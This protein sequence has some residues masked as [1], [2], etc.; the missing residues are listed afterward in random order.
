MGPFVAH[1]I[2]M[3][4]KT[5]ATSSKLHEISSGGALRLHKARGLCSARRGWVPMGSRGCGRCDWP[6]SVLCQGPGQ[7]LLFLAA[8]LDPINWSRDGNPSMALATASDRRRHVGTK[9]SQHGHYRQRCAALKVSLG[10]GVDV[11]FDGVLD[12]F[13]CMWRRRGGQRKR[14]RAVE[15]KAWPH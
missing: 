2:M 3:S 15:A 5:S 10:A 1:G 6:R 4:Q 12:S 14:S 11:D 7:T 13:G 9:T 8:A